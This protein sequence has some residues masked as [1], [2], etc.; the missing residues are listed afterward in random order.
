MKKIFFDIVYLVSVFTHMIPP[1]IE[2]YTKQISR[3][4]KKNGKCLTSMFLLQN[5]PKHLKQEWT[6]KFPQPTLSKLEGNPLKDHFMVGNIKNP[7]EWV[8]YDLNYI[9]SILAL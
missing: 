9:L 5:N 1:S 3:V 6:E 8:I 4:L 2:N 7:E